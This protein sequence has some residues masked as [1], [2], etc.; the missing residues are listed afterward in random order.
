MIKIVL[1]EDH[2][3]VAEG[4]RLMLQT[5]S[6]YQLVEHFY[7]GDF[8]NQK[9]NNIKPDLIIMD[10]NLGKENGIE[11]VRK[12][13]EQFPEKPYILM[14]TMHHQPQ[15]VQMAMQS[16][17]N[18]YVVKSAGKEEF[19]QAIQN[20]LNG[21]DY[22]SRE[23]VSNMMKALKSSKRSSPNISL[24]KRE[25]EIIKL[26]SQGLTSGLI[27]EKLSLSSKTVDTHRRNI[28]S[29]LGVKNSAEAVKYAIDANLIDPEL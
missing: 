11:L 6:E 29:K 24:S 1:V 3:I 18:G 21:S 20:V 5:N 19:L 28:L 13:R 14:L 17:A 27:G 2:E 7:N 9:I 4:I 16:G 15:I 22:F 26:L 10:I 8:L 12:I 25:I 23:V